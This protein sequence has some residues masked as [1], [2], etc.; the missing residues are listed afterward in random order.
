MMR[1]DFSRYTFD[2]KK[3]YSG[4]WMQQGRVQLDADWNE[5]QSINLHRSLTEAQ[6]TVGRCGAPSLDPGFQIKLDKDGDLQIGK[7]RYYVDGM[8]CE[9]D[10]EVKYQLQPNLPSA[11]SIKD[12]LKPTSLSPICYGMVYLDV[13]QRAITSLDDPSLKETALG[14]ADTATRT[15]TIWQ[16]KVYPLKQKPSLPCSG[17]KLFRD[18]K[19]A[20]NAMV[21]PSD[22]ASADACIIRPSAGYRRL[23][24]QL[25]R[26]EIHK[27][28]KLNEA[29][30]KWSQDNASNEISVE[31][32][33]GGEIKIED[34][35]PAVY[36]IFKDGSWVEVV[37]DNS[38][39]NPQGGQP[40]NLVRL[41]KDP[42]TAANVFTLEESLNWIGDLK[43]ARLRK[44]AS[45]DIPINGGWTPLGNEGIGVFFSAESDDKQDFFKSGDYW[46]I[47]AR[48]ATGDIEWPKDDF[49]LNKPMPPLGIEHHY[50]NLAV[51]SYD[52]SKLSV[53]PDYDCRIIFPP[54]TGIKASDVSFNGSTVQSALEEL[55]KRAECS[56]VLSIKPGWGWEKALAGIE[57]KKDAW[58][59]FG[60][61]L[62][63]LKRTVN[64]RNKGNIKIV[65]SGPGTKIVIQSA[66][67][68]LNFESCESVTIKDLYAESGVAGSWYK[69]NLSHLNGTVTFSACPKV[70]LESVGLKCKTGAERAA[71]CITVRDATGYKR[72]WR[73][74][75]PD[76]QIVSK[77]V[78]FV[79]ISNC[80]LEV[81]H[82]QSGILLINAKRCQVEGNLIRAAARTDRQ[83]FESLLQNPRYRSSV[84]SLLINHS[85]MIKQVKDMVPEEGNKADTSKEKRENDL[86][87]VS[88]SDYSI[89][90]QTHP[91]LLSS[92]NSW[93]KL[94]RPLGVQSSRDL[95]L[96]MI[97][98]ADRV[99]LNGGVLKKNDSVFQ[100]F[101]SFYDDLR[102]A[103]VDTARQGIVVGGRSAE[104]VSI[105][106]NC[107]NDVH[108]GI[109]IG[110]GQG[111]GV[112]SQTT[113]GI[114][115]I[116]DNN[117][118]IILS[119]ASRG[120][121][122]IFV[123][124]FDSLFLENNYIEVKKFRATEYLHIDG[125]KVRGYLG[126]MAVV[127]C[128]CILQANTAVVF[129]NLNKIGGKPLHIIADNWPL[130]T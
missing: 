12:L 97:R 79:R 8:I 20:L 34:A 60:V 117:I 93:F 15:K 101:K 127:R 52:G 7:G 99:L 6:D 76:K 50:C 88:I 58:I 112:A 36:E 11:P 70:M 31:I 108:Q 125:I 113:G 104:E 124:S 3:R 119:P 64:L 105:R 18:D 71:T 53:L 37:D 9:N 23:D 28:G 118:R 100:G 51:I 109:H 62:Y 56:C 61:G 49:R 95:M 103:D 57:D 85:Q 90:F 126:K 47:P 65:G 19:I 98:V 33:P 68:A 111:Q 43:H 130:D 17:M 10:A 78:E 91:S 114:V 54:L 66:E 87:S 22:E 1:G 45:K 44:W 75:N 5:Q 94:D 81:G 21:Y 40:R 25:Y 72:S 67:S 27:G 2:Q 115:R 74:T 116:S 92:W 73:R 120:R 42:N 110:F 122:G 38:D 13:W 48:I 24:N 55:N 84:R 30:F 106:N 41:R 32:I 96:H 29:T 129:K 80:D 86:V 69:D 123:G 89:S 83:T 39:L 4:V 63:P 102:S 59:C 107:I 128:N 121:E 14:G 77:P 46:V 35:S 82:Q 26:I 16:V